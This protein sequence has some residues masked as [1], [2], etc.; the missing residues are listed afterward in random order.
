MVAA[1]GQLD[2]ALIMID[3]DNFKSV[4]EVYG[5]GT[6]DATLCK[7]A[8]RL[9]TCLRPED[10][11]VRLGGD[12]FL[13]AVIG[14]D[15]EEGVV[16]AERM[17][18]ALGHADVMAGGA[19]L[20]L[21]AS[22]GIA[23]GRLA[24]LLGAADTALLQA[25]ADGKGRIDV[26]GEARSRDAEEDQLL[27]VTSLA[28]D[29]IFP[30]ADAIVVTNRTRRVVSAS[31]EY[32]RVVGIPEADIVGQSP[33]V[34]GAELTDPAVYSE[35][36]RRLEEAGR[37]RGELVNRRPSGE[38]WW[39]DWS[40]HAVELRGR[41]FGYLGIARDVTARH[42]QEAEKVAGA[43]GILVEHNDP[44]ISAHLQ[45]TRRIMQRVVSEWQERYGR[46]GLPLNPEEYAMAASLHDVGKIT[47]PGDILNKPGPLTPAERAVVERHSEEGFAYLQR[48][49]G[50]WSH[51]AQ[52]EYMRLFLAVA[53]DIALN[54]HERYD[55]AGYPRK[56]RGLEIPLAA[57]LFS[58][59]DVYDAL[60]SE[61]PY[62]A[63][64]SEREAL[65][66]VRDNAGTMFDPEAAA[67]LI[68]VLGEES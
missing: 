20:R 38:V 68:S 7:A 45:R 52:S 15:K 48:L 17:L 23:V 47:I 1:S 37:W 53:M 62:K 59:I 10:A 51:G 19:Q 57:R 31:P 55:G 54:H 65:Q 32:E 16:I 36:V 34:M 14:A 67:L 40:L 49:S 46:K 21:D 8:N 11:L 2:G 33:S 64:W 9:G 12:E 4:N 22:I 50:Y 44:S 58:P 56:V 35:M 28:R 30:S 3:L 39:S 42:R 43:V 61:R 18:L 25:K 41:R 63:A 13:S 6:G 27:R 29:M 24:D 66:Y 60:I 5:H 26:Y